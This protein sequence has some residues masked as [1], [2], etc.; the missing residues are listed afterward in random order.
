MPVNLTLTARNARPLVSDLL[1]ADLDADLTVR[2]ALQGRI[3]A[4]GTVRIRRA[5][6]N[7]PDRL[8]TSVAVLNVRNLGAPPPPPPMPGPTIGLDLTALRRAGVFIRGHGLEAE[9]A[10]RLHLGGTSAAL[11]ASGG[12]QLRSGRSAWPAPRSPS[13]RARS[14]STA[15]A[16]ATRSTRRSTSSPPTPPETSPPPSPISGYADAPK[17]TLSSVPDLPQDEVLAHLLFGQSAKD[18]GPFQYAQIAEALA[19]LS[20]V[21]GGIAG[22]PLNSVRKG[23]GLDRLSVGSSTNGNGPSLQAGR[24]VARG[25]YL[26]AQQGTGG[27]TQ[28]TLQIDLY[29]GLKLQTNVGSSAAG[30]S[31]VG[32]TYQFEYR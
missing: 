32:L 4:G 15:A 19:S 28:G 2:G 29:K 23:L 27:D 12:F 8:P 6:I 5:D 14:A 22:D 11:A 20:G 7:I 9:M 10:G 3:D 17:F 1:T 18:L 13:P 16:C 31:S 26:G 25:V 21:G 24:Y 30:G